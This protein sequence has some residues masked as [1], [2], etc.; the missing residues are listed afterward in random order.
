MPRQPH[1]ADWDY[2]FGPHAPRRK[3][4]IAL[5]VT[6]TL[7]L[8]FVVAL[9]MGGSFGLR[10]Y[11]RYV[12]AQALTATPLW[13]QYYVQQT[14]TAQAAAVTPTPAPTSAATATVNAVSNLRS[15]P[16]IAPETVLGQMA[17][18]DVVIILENR[19]V[20]AATWFRVR[21]QTTTGALAP[22]TE[23]WISSTLINQ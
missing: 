16:R 13:A 18:G 15:E 6:L 19:A 21:V 23:G 5:F 12:A 22:N 14:A 17:A 4:P 7:V 8:V 11:D 2:F 10:R 1:A 3:G 20:G 9:Y